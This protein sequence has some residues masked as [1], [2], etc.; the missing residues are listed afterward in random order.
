PNLLG[1]RPRRSVGRRAAA[2]GLVVAGTVGGFTAGQ[3]IAAHRWVPAWAGQ[4]TAS[5]Q[6][7]L[8]LGLIPFLGLAVLG[9]MLLCRPESRSGIS[10]APMPTPDGPR[11]PASIARCR[12]ARSPSS[13]VPPARARPRWRAA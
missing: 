3:L 13:W 2:L 11:C 1:A 5:G 12:P 6:R 7:E 8:G 4:A 10:A 9:L